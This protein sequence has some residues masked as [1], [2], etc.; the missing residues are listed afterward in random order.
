MGAHA[1]EFLEFEAVNHFVGDEAAG[2]S[3]TAECITAM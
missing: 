3:V 1:L 2:A